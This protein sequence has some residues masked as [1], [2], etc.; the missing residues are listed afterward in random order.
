MVCDSDNLISQM[1]LH[2]NFLDNS[3]DENHHDYIFKKIFNSDNPLNEASFSYPEV[4][5]KTDEKQIKDN[6]LSVSKPYNENGS[7]KKDNNVNYILLN[8]EYETYPV[9]KKKKTKTQPYSKEVY[10]PEIKKIN[11]GPRIESLKENYSPN[12]I[13]E[14]KRGKLKFWVTAISFTDT[15]EDVDKN[16]TIHNWHL[17]EPSDNSEPT[18]S[19]SP[20][21]EESYSDPSLDIND[22]IPQVIDNI[23][24]AQNNTQDDQDNS[25]SDNEYDGDTKN[26]E[27]VLNYSKKLK[28]FKIGS[29]KH[30]IDEHENINQSDDSF[31]YDYPDSYKKQYRNKVFKKA[32][33]HMD[34]RKSKKIYKSWKNS[35]ITQPKMKSIISSD[36]AQLLGFKGTAPMSDIKKKTLQR[37]KVIENLRFI[38]SKQG[39]GRPKTKNNI[40]QSKY[41]LTE[42][43]NDAPKIFNVSKKFEK[44]NSTKVLDISEN[45]T[46]NVL[47]QKDDKEIESSST[48][49]DILFAYENHNI[50]FDIYDIEMNGNDVK[51][52]LRNKDLFYQVNNEKKQ[53]YVNRKNFHNK[54]NK[55]FKIENR[56]TIK[57][58]IDKLIP[59]DSN[60]LQKHTVK[61][62]ADDKGE[63]IRKGVFLKKGIPLQFNPYQKISNLD[64]NK[65]LLGLQTRSPIGGSQRKLINVNEK[66]YTNAENIVKPEEQHN[67]PLNSENLKSDVKRN[68]MMENR[69][70]K[71]FNRFL[72]DIALI[73]FLN[74]NSESIFFSD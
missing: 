73:K 44:K 66:Q 9:S 21:A 50:P 30:T 34:K 20:E 15:S 19:Y 31:L 4:L 40:L 56:F 42:K 7:L 51:T 58:D 17:S 52:K 3:K 49:E 8:E 47:L 69:Y 62:M 64:D 33:E 12:H 46:N 53:K 55:P 27:D 68:T 11:S 36:R 57:R 13:K 54:F 28:K 41:F 72:R 60:K 71:A 32:N 22:V 29:S 35:L 18:N 38:F 65:Q 45:S 74:D 2:M 39:T 63:E 59:E 48:I 1:T 10:K 16:N 25:S 23:E 37:Q 61:R 14:R 26:N 70:Q 67:Y 43:T 6:E 5:D 24:Q